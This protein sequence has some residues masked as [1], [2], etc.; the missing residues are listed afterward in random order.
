MSP[1][2]TCFQLVWVR[3]S[4]LSGTI[5]PELGGLKALQELRLESNHLTGEGCVVCSYGR[6]E[7]EVHS[8]GRV[9]TVL[10]L[11]HFRRF[12]ASWKSEASAAVSLPFRFISAISFSSR[13]PAIVFL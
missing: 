13:R 10:V 4:T 9:S 12:S 3:S 1:P 5:P 2:V 8:W 7:P 11:L 6:V